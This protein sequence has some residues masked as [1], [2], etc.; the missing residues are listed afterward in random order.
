M[1]ATPQKFPPPP[2]LTGPQFQPLNRWL[3]ELQSALSNAGGID[4]NNIPGFA[5]LETQVAANTAAITTL[6]GTS[7][8]L[9]ARVTTLEATVAAISGEITTINATLT[10][11]SARAQV[12]NGSGAPGAGL[13][14]VNDWYA[15]TSGS[16]HIY[17]KTAVSTWTQIV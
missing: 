1:A 2:Q 17:V 11:L 7:G 6:E 5:T 15:D 9:S 10:A 13:G 3:L 16:H 4:P 14:N 8:S 12:L